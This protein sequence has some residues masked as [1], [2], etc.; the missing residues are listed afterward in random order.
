MP[1]F[2]GYPTTTTPDPDALL[3]ILDGDGETKACT[4]SALIS[5]Q[6]AFVGIRVAPFSLT[7]A[8]IKAL[9]A[10]GFELVP[11][12]GA[13]KVLVFIAA[14][15]KLDASGGAYVNLDQYTKFLFVQTTPGAGYVNLGIGGWTNEIFE[16]ASRTVYFI[17]NATPDG[18]DPPAALLGQNAPSA[19]AENKGLWLA[20]QN[21]LGPLTGG[22][23]ANTFSG[24]VLYLELDVS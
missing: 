3:L 4:L 18:N 12:P 17:P 23:P 21:D 13:G 8:E 11:A 9:P 2:E 22:N 15:G 16:A 24:L 10:D 14:V 20:M 6:L 19:D 1:Q 7:D 5:A